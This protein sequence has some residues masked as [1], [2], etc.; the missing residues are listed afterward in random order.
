MIKCLLIALCLL[1]LVTT[2]VRA[3]E[4]AIK[5]SLGIRD[6][7][8]FM[9]KPFTNTPCPLAFQITNIGKTV[10]SG[11][12]ARDLFLQGDIHVLSKDGKQEYA[13]CIRFENSER[14]GFNAS[15]LQPGDTFEN[16]I[17]VDLLDFFP[18]IRDGDYQVWW[19]VRDL[20]SNVLLFTVTDGK[21][22]LIKPETS[23]DGSSIKR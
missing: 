13:D 3:A 5:I 22:Q 12:E 20:K 19:T 15:D 17:I 9:G 18:L 14:F 1:T 8:V 10:L 7:K 23:Y 2:S 21:L 4:P 6:I 11:G 16:K